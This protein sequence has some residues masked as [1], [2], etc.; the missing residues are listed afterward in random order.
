MPRF[1]FLLPMYKVQSTGVF[2][3][4]L[5]HEEDKQEPAWAAFRK[6]WKKSCFKLKPIFLGFFD[7]DFLAHKCKWFHAPS[8]Q[9]KTFRQPKA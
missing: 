1:W 6:L 8:F 9:V 5:S 4:C 3:L 2:S 7:P